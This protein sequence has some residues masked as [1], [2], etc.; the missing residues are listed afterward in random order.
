M[1][2]CMRAE[3]FFSLNERQAPEILVVEGWIGHQGM[4]AAKAEFE[5]GNYQCIVT[6]GGPMNNRWASQ[7]WNYAT[8]SYELL[9]RL[10]VPP[11]RVIAAP[12]PDVE[13]HRTFES[14]VVVR[15]TLQK[16]NFQ[17]KFVNIFTFGVHARRSRLVFAKVLAPATTVGVISWIP[18]GYSDGPWWKSS[19][20]SLN[21]IK[22]TVG[23]MFELLLNSGRRSNH[24]TQMSNR[25]TKAAFLTSR[26]ISVLNG[27]TSDLRKSKMVV[28]T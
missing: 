23:Y 9:I 12:A 22:E 1:W 25:G 27:A 6:S 4:D 16:H 2:W 11:D 21:L 13:N 15:D 5:R 18:N 26:R 24:P 20:R 19:E 3:N 10:G 7:R 14:A 28:S 8:E 17:P